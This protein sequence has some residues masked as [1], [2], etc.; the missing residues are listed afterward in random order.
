MGLSGLVT[1]V[2]GGTIN[3]YCSASFPSTDTY[4]GLENYE[5]ISV[6]LMTRHGD[7]APITKFPTGS[8][9]SSG[10]ATRWVCSPGD[11]SNSSVTFQ[12]MSSIKDIRF[13]EGGVC[14]KDHLTD[15]G[16][17]QLA[18][19]GKELRQIYKAQLADGVFVNT[20]WTQRTYWS[21]VALMSGLLDSK[22]PK[23][24]IH[25]KPLKKDGLIHLYD[26]C[27][28]GKH[29]SEEF[30]KTNEFQSANAFLVK[31][32]NDYGLKF[33]D[34]PLAAYLAVDNLRCLD[35]HQMS[36]PSSKP[37]KSTIYK[38][39]DEFIKAMFFPASSSAQL[40]RMLIGTYLK[41]LKQQ[42]QHPRKETMPRF[43][44]TSA[45]DVSI[46]ALL[47]SLNFTSTGTPPYA[48]NFITELWAKKSNCRSRRNSK[49]V[50]FLYNGK[51]VSPP[52]CQAV[53]PLETF[54]NYIGQ[55]G[56]HVSNESHPEF[57]FESEC[58]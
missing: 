51:V 4:T 45:H 21:A 30:I 5:L 27:R 52:W 13:E 40:H 39:T 20:T 53:C 36:L 15:K 54:L 2:S 43:F 38:A 16:I 37:D 48:S 57:F 7:R 55:L 24:V 18:Q 50:R 17:H 22:H 14:S 29:L 31:V 12:G 56:I 35:C 8:E 44:Y 3:P 33:R 41:D 42:L 19:L 25:S 23:F 32:A 1:G 34:H 26:K 47:S 11:I 49:H 10:P 6:H 58:E 28:L 46:S 9:E